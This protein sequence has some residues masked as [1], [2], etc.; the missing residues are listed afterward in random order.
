M[1]SFPP[2]AMTHLEMIGNAC[3]HARLSAGHKQQ[4]IADI[5]GV[6]KATVSRFENGKSNNALLYS[7]YLY[8]YMPGWDEMIP[9]I[10]NIEKVTEDDHG[11]TILG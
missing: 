10:A 11:V 4:L 9:N 2:F 8:L 3:R 6:D 7:I 5:A 1:K